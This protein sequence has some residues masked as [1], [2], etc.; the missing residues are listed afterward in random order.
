MSDIPYRFEPT[1]TAAAILADHDALDDGTESGVT[2]TI[3]GRMMLRRGQGKLIF[4]V[5][6]DATGRIQL[7]APAKT[8]PEFEAFGNLSLGDWIG[9]TGEVMKTKRGE[10]SVRVD[11]WI[12]L[13]RWQGAF[14]DKW[15]G[16]T[17]IDVRYR[18]RYV[19]LWVN[20]ESR[21]RLINRSRVVSGVRRHLDERGFLEVETPM[22]HPIVGGATAR[23]F[24]THHNALDTDLFLRI[25]P[26]LYLKR[27]VV[28]GIEK[29]FEIG[30]NFRN[31]GLSTR[32]NPE[33]TMM[34][35]Y[36]AYADTRTAW[37]WS[38]SSCRHLRSRS[39][40]QPR[41]PLA[42]ATSNWLPHGGARPWPN[43]SKNTP[44]RRPI[45]A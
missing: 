6:Q 27:L 5:L 12:V 24:T 18:Q 26:E 19:D 15:H 1:A 28:G 8:T 33:F 10:V 7:F 32:H 37:C 45:S 34:E 40:A 42:T 29:V 23:P 43:S 21:E 17:D 38:R 36:W 22:L 30:R 39:R 11:E 2:V 16:V 41:S 14:P 25:A 3:A 35:L 31:E 20:D 9:V 13:A 4:G 44:A